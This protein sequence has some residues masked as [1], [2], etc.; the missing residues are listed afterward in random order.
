MNDGFTLVALAAFGLW[1]WHWSSIAHERVLAISGEI[2]R[3]L[4]LQRL[5]DTVA[6]RR[7]TVSL[8]GWRCAVRRIYSFDF[9][10]TGEDRRRAEICLKSAILEWVRIDH[11]DGPILI[12]I[13]EPG[14]AA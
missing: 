6:L 7:I 14:T 5:D 13:S 11:P 12:Q 1:V 9:S 3:D 4:K 2:C 10:T 8:T